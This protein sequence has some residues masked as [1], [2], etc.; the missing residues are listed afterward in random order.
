MTSLVSKIIVKKSSLQGLWGVILGSYHTTSFA[1]STAKTSALIEA[2]AIVD[3]Q[4]TKSI[5]TVVHRDCTLVS[6]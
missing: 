1:E 3:N 6:T 2:I 4:L 5:Y